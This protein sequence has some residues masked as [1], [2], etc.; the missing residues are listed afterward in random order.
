M[1]RIIA[2]TPDGMETDHRDG[3]TLNNQVK[4]LRVCT[5]SQNL[6]NARKHIN[7]TSGFKGVFPHG[8][9]WKVQIRVG[10]KILHIGVYSTREEAAHAYDKAA[11]KYHG[12]FANLNF[13]DG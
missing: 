8:S 1:H 13:P 3:D 12:E 7:N 9:N 11:I 4:N 6:S 2:N 10:G 5:H